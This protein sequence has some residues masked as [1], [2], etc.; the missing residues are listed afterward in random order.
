MK[1][2]FIELILVMNFALTSLN[3]LQMINIV[4]HVLMMEVVE[5]VNLDID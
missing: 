2:L 4:L 5:N 1:N 3:V